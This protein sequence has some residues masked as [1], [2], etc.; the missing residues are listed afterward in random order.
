M[1]EQ[2]IQQLNKFKI[3]REN[4][5]MR[6]MN[7]GWKSPNSL[8]IKVTISNGGHVIDQFVI[9]QGTFCKIMSNVYYDRISKMIN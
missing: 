5:N 4:T 3:E 6:P 2:K 7:V 9:D 1:V 8:N